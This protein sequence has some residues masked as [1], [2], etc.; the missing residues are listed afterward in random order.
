MQI[1]RTKDL[2]YIPASHEDPTNPGVLKKV[3]LTKKDIIFGQIQMIN[4]A[5][6][7][8]GNS[9]RKHHHED[10]QE[11]FIVLEGEAEIIIDGEKDML[12]KGDA[13]ITPIG[14]NHEMQNHTSEDVYYIA[15]GISTSKEGKTIV[16]A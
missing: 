2:Q 1:V 16:S 3:L 6:L 12:Y 9:F 15:I 4:W 11:I 13:V 8:P 14:K 7:P 10:M 5:K